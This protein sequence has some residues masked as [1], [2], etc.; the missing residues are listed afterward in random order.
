MIPN[1]SKRFYA[2]ALA[3]FRRARRRALLEQ[4]LSGLSG[5]SADLLSFDQVRQQL[6][7][8]GSQRRQLKEIPLD[9]IVGS[10]GRC[11]DFTRSFLPQRDSDERR[12]ARVEMAILAG[13]A[14]PTLLAV[15]VPGDVSCRVP[16]CMGCPRDGD[17]E[18][19]LRAVTG[20]HV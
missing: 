20:V 4:I 15:P 11:A 9:A 16:P 18:R 3:D 5:K 14:Y 10:V 2:E 8:G 6:K 12:W 1:G 17:F 7:I 13:I 19:D